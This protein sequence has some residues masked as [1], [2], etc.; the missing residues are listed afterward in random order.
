MKRLF[1][2][3]SI[4]AICVSA[5]ANDYDF[6]TMSEPTCYNGTYAP[7]AAPIA[8]A[9]NEKMVYQ[10]GLFDQL[11]MIGND[12]LEPIATSAFVSAIDRTQETPVWTVGITGAA[13]IS[14]ITA[15]DDA[16]Y[17][18]GTF[19]DDITFGSRDMA[20]KDISGTS[21]S[22][23]YVNAFI[24][25]Y[26]TNGNLVAAA[27][28][29]PQ[30]NSEYADKESYDS[31]LCIEPTAIQLFN[32]KIYIS[33][34]Y[35]G[36]YSTE[37]IKTDGNLKSSFGFFD[38]RCC[39]IV[40][41][42]AENL[43]GAKKVLDLRNAEAI[44][45]NG[46]CP[47]SICLTAD[48]SNLYVASFLSGD[49]TLTIADKSQNISFSHNENEQV[50]G[51]IILTIA[52][53]GSYTM[54]QKE[55]KA[56]DRAYIMNDIAWMKAEGGNLYMAGNVSTPLPFDDSLVPDLWT[57]QFAACLSTTDFNCKWAS[58][59]G[60]KRDDMATGND[61]YRKSISASVSGSELTLI[62]KANFICSSKGMTPAYEGSTCLGT[63]SSTSVSA[64]TV[65]TDNGC[66]LSVDKKVPTGIKTAT[67]EA[68]ESKAMFDL[69]GRS[70]AAPA[71]G[72][73]II[74]SNKKSIAQ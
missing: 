20:T 63:A 65:K 43:T 45:E 37:D 29:L 33:F 41:Y 21:A 13:H 30:K 38:S 68:S 16:V 3:L 49:N 52:N 53:D 23:D 61:K 32:G 17:V 69:S 36:G 59:T 51:A 58:I 67:T 35:L 47:Q 72:Q 40:S 48:A 5:H 31:D 8:I 28:V 25:K 1:T 19:A 39:A 66:R 15:T 11:T 71:K 34:K 54:S 26:T 56:S 24:A 46:M 12:I 7:I 9:P 62:G 44:N 4:A 60:A 57:D 55:A 42:D 73:I 64:T 27:S 10:A 70:I 50:Y 18:A 74:K 2:L 14:L 22:H 6:P